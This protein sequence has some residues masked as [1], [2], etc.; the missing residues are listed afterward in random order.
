MPIDRKALIRQYKE[1]RRPAGVFRVQNTV[2]G[3]SLVGTSVDL[4][5]MLNRQRAQ[6]RM[7]GHDNRALQTDWDTL[8][9]DAF[10][11]EVL[12]VLTPPE[13][14]DWNPRDELHVLE[15]LWLEKLAPLGDRG[16][17]PEPKPRA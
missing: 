5:S 14:A 6:L 17:N 13:Q 8:G 1:T 10:E 16:Y 3:K 4:P 15:K 2:N 9:A 7:G 12:D 11:F